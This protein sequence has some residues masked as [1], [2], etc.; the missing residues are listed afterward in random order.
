[1]DVN[2]KHKLDE[3]EVCRLRD[4]G[5]S[6]R[7]LMDHFDATVIEIAD[8][9]EKHENLK[10][11]EKE[12]EEKIRKELEEKAKQRD[13]KTTY[14]YLRTSTPSQNFDLQ[15]KDITDMCDRIDMKI[16]KI[17]KDKASG[18]NMKRN[19]LQE[20]LKDIKD[21][22]HGAGYVF[23]WSVDRLGRDVDDLNFLINTF[24]DNNMFFS[25]VSDGMYDI[26]D[27]KVLGF[28]I[29]AHLAAIESE[30]ISK[31]VKAG[32]AAKKAKE[33]KK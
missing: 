28:V 14:V 24:N 25:T 9:C 26:D 10:K 1:M 6:F 22:T 21:N 33:N 27:P 3:E 8:I 30:R 13:Y 2:K 11:E 17:Y 32:I 5:Y 18:L 7:M 15:I 19:G 16:I 29:A 31:R 20:M 12:K 4:E 23:A